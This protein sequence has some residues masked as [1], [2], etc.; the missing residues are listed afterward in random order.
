MNLYVSENTVLSFF[1]FST[2]MYF[3]CNSRL[4]DFSKILIKWIQT[5]ILQFNKVRIEIDRVNQ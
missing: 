3:F 2:F 4:Q 1:Q 5:L